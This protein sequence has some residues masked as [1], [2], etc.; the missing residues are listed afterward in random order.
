MLNYSAIHGGPSDKVEM[1]DYF[2]S[3]SCASLEEKFNIFEIGTEMNEMPYN[4]GK[5]QFSIEECQKHLRDGYNKNPSSF[6]Y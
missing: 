4:F 1:S 6:V 2:L 3:G 5:K